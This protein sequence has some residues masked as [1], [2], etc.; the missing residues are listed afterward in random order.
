MR[1]Q[2]RKCETHLTTFALSKSEINALCKEIWT[3]IWAFNK[4]IWPKTMALC[5]SFGIKE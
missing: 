1:Q 3:H 2:K 5:P 4:E